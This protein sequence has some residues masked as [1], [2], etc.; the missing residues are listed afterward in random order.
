MR[1]SSGNPANIQSGNIARVQ[2]GKSASSNQLNI[3]NLNA[4]TFGGNF[5]S[6][7]L[8]LNHRSLEGQHCKDVE[9]VDKESKNFDKGQLDKEG[10]DVENVDKKSKNVEK[11]SNDVE[12]VDKIY[13]VVADVKDAFGSV[14]HS[15]LVNILEEIRRKLPK[16]LFVHQVTVQRKGG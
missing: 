10:K 11:E 7:N 4:E 9:N 14:V 16:R 5:A 2:S 1:L 3:V 6:G 13:V 12:N 8:A 15:K